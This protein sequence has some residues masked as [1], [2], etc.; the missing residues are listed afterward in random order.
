VRELT[1]AI[2][3]QPVHAGPECPA[4]RG[5]P[6]GSLPQVNGLTRTCGKPEEQAARITLES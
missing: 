5:V 2:P 3:W 4:A 1:I 6:V